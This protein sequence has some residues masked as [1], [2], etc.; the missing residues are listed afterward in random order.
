MPNNLLTIQPGRQQIWEI[1][2]LWGLFV[3]V[4]RRV[5]RYQFGYVDSI[6]TYLHLLFKLLTIWVSIRFIVYIF[7]SCTSTKKKRKEKKKRGVIFFTYG[8]MGHYF[9]CFL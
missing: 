6:E 3:Q 2:L 4:K 8:V 5:A 1:E 9:W 7:Y